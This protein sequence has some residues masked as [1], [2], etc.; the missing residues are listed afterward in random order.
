MFTAALVTLFGCSPDGPGKARTDVAAE[1]SAGLGGPGVDGGDMADAGDGGDVE[2]GADAEAGATV[3]RDPPLLLPAEDPDAILVRD[4]MKGLFPSYFPRSNDDLTKSGF[5]PLDD[6]S[7]LPNGGL[8]RIETEQWLGRFLHPAANP[9]ALGRDVR[10]TIHHLKRYKVDALRHE[11]T[12]RVTD[13]P[14]K[15]DVDLQVRITE[16]NW[17]ITIEILPVGRGILPKAPEERLQAITWLGK[18][19]LKWKGTH[20]ELGGEDTPHTWLF[21]YLHLRNEAHFVT[22]PSKLPFSMTSWADRLDGGIWREYLYFVGYKKRVPG[23]G[24]GSMSSDEAHWFDGK[25]DEAAEKAV[26][27]RQERRRRMFEQQE[28]EQRKKQEEEERKKQKEQQQ[29]QP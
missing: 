25:S 6:Y 27:E 18:R 11:L 8:V 14:G 2:G 7:V 28:E 17:R 26:Q 5:V 19:V 4:R 12:A 9:H 24:E 21:R 20:L 10:R 16:T 1:A 15:P 13:E 3:E 22:D 23:N 29:Q